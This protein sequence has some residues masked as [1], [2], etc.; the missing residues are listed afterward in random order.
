MR[1]FWPLV[2]Y[3]HNNMDIYT[4][5]WYS[6]ELCSCMF[7]DKPIIGNTHSKTLYN[8]CSSSQANCTS[9]SN[10]TSSDCLK[11]LCFLCFFQIFPVW[12]PLIWIFCFCLFLALVSPSKCL[13]PSYHCQCSPST[14]S[15]TFLWVSCHAPAGPVFPYKVTFLFPHHNV[16][17]SH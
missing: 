14:A 15:L 7:L 16:V 11:L 4:I 12:G 3:C 5:I 10:T 6:Q 8:Y 13:Y 1:F 2:M 17:I 9:F